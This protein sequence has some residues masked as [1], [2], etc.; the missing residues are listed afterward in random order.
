MIAT[1]A[2]LFT[3]RKLLCMVL[4]LSCQGVLA[5]ADEGDELVGSVLNDDTVGLVY[6]AAD[7]T[8]FTPRNVL[9][10]L[11]RV[12]GFAVQN[13]SQ[14]RGLGQASTNVLI[15]GKRLSSKS[16]NVFDQL[17]RVTVD[18]LAQIE[19]V[20][21]A[22]LD[23]P[24]LSGQVANIVTRY[25]DISGRYN[26][27][28]MHRPKYAKPGWF[29]GEAS[30]NGSTESIEW[31]LA[32]THGNGRGGAGGPGIIRDA[33]R[34][35]TE[36]RD[37]RVQFTGEFPRLSGSLTWNGP[38]DTVANLNMQYSRR[39]TD[40]SNDE[41]R[42]PLD[43]INSF[44]DFDNHDR[45]YNYE[46]GG[47]IEFDLAFGTLKLIGLERAGRSTFGQVSTLDYDDTRPTTGSRFLGESEDSERIA[48]SEYRW[49]MLGGNWEV[50]LEAAFNTL[51]QSSQ[52]FT[53]GE[54]GDFQETELPN[55]SGEVTEDRYEML[56]THSHDLGDDLNVQL[57]FGGEKSE[58][59]QSGPRGLTRNFWRN[60]GSLN[61]GWN[62]NEDWDISLKFSRAVGQLSFGDFLASVSLAFDNENAGNIQLRPTQTW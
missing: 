17:R 24:G 56:I 27:R 14:G 26:W 45:G 47:D 16:Q 33:N 38:D 28:T 61:F 22:T 51:D 43:G 18:N 6:T 35:V 44:R 10:I 2:S 20:D 19:I 21:G 5:Q 42:Q 41:Y 15:N 39:Y 36:L 46:I 12:P 7:F 8:R 31:N 40:F 37:V 57:T 4:L 13:D 48:R 54:N 50:D 49:D 29:G 59:S 52:F 34:N 1:A 53:L 25:G 9:D 55:G 3:P 58:L 32:Y 62:P 23:M 60:K 30:V 11:N